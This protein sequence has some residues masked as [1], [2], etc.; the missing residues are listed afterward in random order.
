MW[1]LSAQSSVDSRNGPQPLPCQMYNQLGL[2][3]MML[4][5]DLLTVIAVYLVMYFG[6]L[7]EWLNLLQILEVQGT[8]R[9]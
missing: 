7:N 9:D 5:I 2:S 1:L 3:R 6:I 4:D 8:E